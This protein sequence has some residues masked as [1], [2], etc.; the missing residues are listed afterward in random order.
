MR[1]N[2]ETR[3][4]APL[5][6]PKNLSQ[7]LL[8]GSYNTCHDHPIAFHSVPFDSTPSLLDRRSPRSQHC[9]QGFELDYQNRVVLCLDMLNGNK[10]ENIDAS[11]LAAGIYLIQVVTTEGTLTKKIIV[12]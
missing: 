11:G 5:T 3:R 12:K 2:E 1:Y 4:Y 8:Q 6:I 10:E 9:F 7:T